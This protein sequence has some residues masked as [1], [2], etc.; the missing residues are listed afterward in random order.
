MAVLEAQV[1]NH[2][3]KLARKVQKILHRNPCGVRLEAHNAPDG[4]E[5]HNLF[6]ASCFGSTLRPCLHTL[7]RTPRGKRLWGCEHCY[8][9]C[10]RRFRL[11]HA[12]RADLLLLRFTNT[13]AGRRGR[14]ICCSSK[15]I[16][17][18][19]LRVRMHV[20]WDW[21]PCRGTLWRAPIIF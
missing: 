2:P 15:R 13:A 6:W 7:R 1:G 17:I 12:L 11:R 20:G 18:H 16:V 3:P 19:C 14:T 5:A 8:A 4:E 10:T 9:L 21:L